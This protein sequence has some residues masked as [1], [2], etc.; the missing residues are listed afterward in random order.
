LVKYSRED[1]PAY[2]LEHLKD[3]PFKTHL[4]RGMKDAV[5]NEPDFH[6]L[7]SKFDSGKLST[8]EV[9]DYNHLDYVWSESAHHDLYSSIM[10]ITHSHSQ[11][12]D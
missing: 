11:S 1:P 2:G 5:M 7:V 3:L 4:F 10:E 8:Y 9:V 6:A 12:T